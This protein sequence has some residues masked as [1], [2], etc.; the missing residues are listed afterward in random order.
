MILIGLALFALGL[1][2]YNMLFRIS[3]AILAMPEIIA[4]ITKLY[5]DGTEFS[6]T[7]IYKECTNNIN[8]LIKKI[9]NKKVR[10]D[11]GLTIEVE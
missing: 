7:E 1:V 5:L 3:A 6:K 9:N 10:L 2:Y 11:N 8:D 4:K